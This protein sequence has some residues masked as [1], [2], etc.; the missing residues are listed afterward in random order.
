MGE[1]FPVAGAL[2]LAGAF[3]IT[4]APPF[5][6]FMSEFAIMRAGLK[7]AFSWAVYVMA[8]L[9]IVSF[10]GFMNRF[11][12]MYYEPSS[13]SNREERQTVWCLAPMWAALIPLPVLGVWWPSSVWDYLTG[14]AA[15][16]AG[17]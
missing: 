12:A 3:A 11:R 17:A 8:A 15:A 7:P 2:W 13:V 16:G 6:L 4:G 1:R 10:I 9:L 5:G 14:I